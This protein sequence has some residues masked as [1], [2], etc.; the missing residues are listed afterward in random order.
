MSKIFYDLDNADALVIGNT[1]E[2]TFEFNADITTATITASVLLAS[3][4]TSVIAFTV[5]KSLTN[6]K[7]FTISLSNSQTAG[8]IANINKELIYTITIDDITYLSG[9]IGIKKI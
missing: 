3:D 1:Y 5:T 7:Q 6:N 4:L 2:Q 8:L 9:K